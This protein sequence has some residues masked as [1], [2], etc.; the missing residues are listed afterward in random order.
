MVGLFGPITNSC[1]RFCWFSDPHNPESLLDMHLTCAN[2]G[3]IPA[4]NLLAQDLDTV[5]SDPETPTLLP[6]LISKHVYVDEGGISAWTI[7]QLEEIIGEL[8]PSK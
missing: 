5:A 8:G 4:G 3:D 7:A 6:D 1:L 2:Y